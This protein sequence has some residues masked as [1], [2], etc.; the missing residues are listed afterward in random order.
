MR[1]LHIASLLLGLAAA[2]LGAAAAESDGDADAQDQAVGKAAF[3]SRCAACHRNDGSGAPGVYPPLKGQLGTY[4]KVEEGRDYLVQ[5]VAYGMYGEVEITGTTYTGIMPAFGSWP[6]EKLAAVLNYV[7]TEFNAETLPPDFQPFTASEV[8][9]R[10]EPRR[11]PRD[12]R[13]QVRAGMLKALES[14]E[15]GHAT[16]KGESLTDIPAIAGAADGFARNCQG[17]HR[18]DGAGATGS[19]PRLTDFVG[20]FTRIEGGREYL[21]RVPGVVYSML[22]D[23]A[24]ADVMNWTLKTF[25]K[26]ELAPDFEPY[27]AKEMARYRADPIE[28]VKKH[29]GRML[30]RMREAGY[31]GPDDDGLGRQ[32]ASAPAR[33]AD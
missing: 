31:I 29:R 17:C 25:G 9:R 14:R 2:P 10:Q 6:D 4:L 16:E 22:D 27:S 19:V 30:E 1:G 18:A 23:A 15:A 33:P 8:A 13:T 21:A 28:Q 12:V 3:E 24:L 7:L 26:G 11:S 20:Y 5:L 32:T